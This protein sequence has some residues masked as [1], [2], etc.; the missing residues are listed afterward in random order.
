MK[1]PNTRRYALRQAPV[2]P[3]P[4]LRLSLSNSSTQAHSV[5]P[6]PASCAAA[7]LKSS[8]ELRKAAQKLKNNAPDSCLTARG[9]SLELANPRL[10]ETSM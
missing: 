4:R 1:T 3:H 2:W 5:L 7:A 6:N 10:E 8:T 9:S